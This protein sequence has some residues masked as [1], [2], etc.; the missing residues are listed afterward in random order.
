MFRA[1]ANSPLHDYLAA[2]V[3]GRGTNANRSDVQGYL[4]SSGTA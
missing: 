4:A 2:L 3:E 1:F